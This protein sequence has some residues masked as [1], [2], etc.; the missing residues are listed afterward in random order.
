MVF[1]TEVL[2]DPLHDPL[3]KI[4]P[5]KMIVSGSRQDFHHAVPDLDDRHIESSSSQI[6]HH[7]LLRLTVVQPVGE[8]R[9]GGFIDDALHVQSCDPARVLRRLSLDIIKVRRYCDDCVCHCLSEK[10]LCILLQLPQDHR[11]DRLWL[12]LSPVDLHAPVRPHM[13]LHGADRAVRVR[14]RLPAGTLSHQPFPFLCKRH[15]TG[16][17]HAPRCPGDNDRDIILHYRYTTVGRPEVDPDY[18]SHVLRCSFLFCL[19]IFRYSLAIP[20][21]KP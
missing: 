3:V 8:R 5:S 13:S 10:F 20:D 11:A 19:I 6:V 1:I 15:Y 17:G 21:F 14:D 9:A 12:I 2:N 18:F 16:R 7:H 4:I